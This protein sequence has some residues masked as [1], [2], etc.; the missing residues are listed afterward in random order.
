MQTKYLIIGNS[1][2]G[3]GAAEAIREV[4]KIGCLTIVS[5]ETY[6]A[7]SRPLISKYLTK[8]RTVDGMLFRSSEFYSL[9]NI[10]SVL[11]NKVK[12]LGLESHTAELDGGEKILWHK[13]LLATG[14]VP[15]VP[16]IGATDRNGVFHFVSLDDAKAIDEFIDSGNKAV[17]IGGGLIGISVAEALKKRGVEVTIVEMKER[18]LNT[19]LDE[20]ASSFAERALEK[21]GVE[22]ITGH[23][24][25]QTMGE[26]VIEAALLEDGQRIPCDLVVVAIG[27]LSR[28]E[29]VQNTEIEVNRG[30]LVDRHMST[31]YP[32]VYCC[33]DAAEAFDFIYEANRVTP[34]WPNAYIGGRVAGFNMAGVRIEYPGGT[35][36][37]SLNYFGLDIASAGLVSPPAEG[38]YEVISGQSDDSYRK[39]VLKDG[40]LV[41]MVCVGDV[42]KSGIVFGLMR[43]RVRVEGFKRALL[44]ED[45][46]LI[47]LPR[48]VW[49]RLLETQP[50]RLAPQTAAEKALPARSYLGLEG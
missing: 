11:G 41:G 29:L 37:N 21:A 5:D 18:I 27:V 36:V 1:A 6:P 9:N 20:V 38:G 14:G 50:S 25:V 43:D 26:P 15:I 17:V 8:E 28:I 24:V 12:T 48:E 44:A 10:T 42:S 31:N 13:L 4:D 19:I 49:H 35:A 7:Y 40:L 22:V 3:I 16:E 33:G 46:G 39:V 23:T 34:I 30:I 47:S 2:G 32:G 45:F